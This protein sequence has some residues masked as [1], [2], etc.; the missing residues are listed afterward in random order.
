[1]RG[2]VGLKPMP[3]TAN[4][5]PAATLG[6]WGMCIAKNCPHK[7]EAWKFCEFISALP[8][9]T[10]MQAH[11]GSPPALKAFYETSKD[12]V[13]KDIYKVMQS[14]VVRPPVPQYAQA[15]D[16][17]QRYVSSALTGRM[18]SGTA[19]RAAAKETRLLLRTK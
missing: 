13:Q 9:V 8:Q 14:T 17:L 6:G 5:R 19:M 4:G 18:S 3:A 10:R 2:K 12:P 16:I 11:R 1:V 7:T 15:S